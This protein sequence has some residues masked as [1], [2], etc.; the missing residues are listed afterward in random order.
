M[1]QKAAQAFAEPAFTAKAAE[2]SL[3]VASGRCNLSSMQALECRHRTHKKNPSSQI[4]VHA[5]H[6]V[7]FIQ[8]VSFLFFSSSNSPIQL[9]QGLKAKSRH[10]SSRSALRQY[11][12]EVALP[13]SLTSLNVFKL[14]TCMSLDRNLQ[15]IN[16]RVEGAHLLNL[17]DESVSELQTK[18]VLH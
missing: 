8:F 9:C 14:C 11:I 13:E 5:V 7:S 1:E 10:R 6:I 2:Q 12:N 4:H 17:V 18:E 16:K 15:R 3:I